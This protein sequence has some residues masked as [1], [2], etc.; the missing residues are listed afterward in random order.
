VGDAW[1]FP[2]LDGEGPCL[3]ERFDTLLRRAQETRDSVLNLCDAVA[4]A[5]AG[6]A[7]GE[8]RDQE[9]CD[10]VT[11]ATAAMHECGQRLLS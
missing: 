5:I 4:A 7:E 8:D 10:A 1:L 6:A 3:Q 9:E 11:A 2:K